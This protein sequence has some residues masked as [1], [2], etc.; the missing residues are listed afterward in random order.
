MSRYCN[1]VWTITAMLPVILIIII[2]VCTEYVYLFKSLVP[3][4]I[5]KDLCVISLTNANHT[6]PL[7]APPFT[8]RW[9]FG[10][11][12]INR[13]KDAILFRLWDW[14]SLMRHRHIPWPLSEPESFRFCLWRLYMLP[15]L[16]SYS[17]YPRYF[18]AITISKDASRVASYT[19]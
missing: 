12:G 13:G 5:V 1:F 4:F 7:G 15:L 19:S 16:P 17:R 14:V 8:Q 11:V 2:A 3:A 10:S 9:Q 18:K 6:N